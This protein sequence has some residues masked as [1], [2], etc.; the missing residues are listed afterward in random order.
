MEELDTVV[1]SS[2][3]SLP[4]VQRR[5]TEELER[6]AA[7]NRERAVE[8]GWAFGSV[9]QLVLE[10]GAWFEPGDEVPG[11]EF[12][13]FSAIAEAARQTRNC[14]VEGY[15]LS[16]DGAVLLR[17]WVSTVERVIVGPA[18]H[19][20]YFGV[21]LAERFRATV[22]R[23]SGSAS[24]LFGQELDRFRLLRTGVAADVRVCGP[25]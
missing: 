20:V 18:P 11:S 5:L 24:V 14:Y 7:P 17:G 25:A 23:R 8:A 9:E 15:A 21:S 22:C 16:L 13:G 6:R 1:V 10:Y 19:V 4:A 12:T 2:R 3:S